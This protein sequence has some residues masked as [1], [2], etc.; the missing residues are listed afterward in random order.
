MHLGQR[1]DKPSIALVGDGHDGAG[2]GNDEVGPGHTDIGREK[3]LA[4]LA[5]RGRGELLEHGRNLDALGLA[6]EPGDVLL[7]LL[8]GWRDDVDRVLLLELEDVLA[9]I[10]LDA[11]DAGR[12]E[13]V[14][15]ADLLRGHRLRLGQELGIVALADLD[16]VGVCL[17]GT[18]TDGHVPSTRLD[19]LTKTLQ[20]GVD[21]ANR[22]HPHLVGTLALSLDIVELTPRVKPMGAQP[23]CG[24][25]NRSLHTSVGEL[26]PR[27]DAEALPRLGEVSHLAPQHRGAT[28]SPDAR[29]GG[30]LLE[31]RARA[32][33]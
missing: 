19:R 14:V 28:R 18:R 6:E 23:L 26:S 8:D 27:D 1:G 24:A 20:V 32:G 10:R 9:E 22:P 31:R 17:L 21:V 25:G 29:S 11:P 33:A 12:L 4:K 13:R 5:P 16:D 30:R 15:Q 3:D 2:L 7:R